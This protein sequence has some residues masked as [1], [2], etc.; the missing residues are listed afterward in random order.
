MHDDSH[1]TMQSLLSPRDL[2]LPL[3][4]SSITLHS[5]ILR[6][7]S[8]CKEQSRVQLCSLKNE[9]TTFIEHI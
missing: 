1:Y 3:R 4:S 5:A 2:V 9:Q 8:T 6:I 7:L